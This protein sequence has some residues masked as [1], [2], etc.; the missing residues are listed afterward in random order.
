MAS[1]KERPGNAYLIR[2]SD[3]YTP[4]GKQKVHTMTWKAPA[5]MT[6]AKAGRKRSGKLSFSRK[7]QERRHG[8]RKR[9]I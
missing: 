6:K 2:V 8:E 5:G 7:M 1:I 3:G 9:K 4:Q